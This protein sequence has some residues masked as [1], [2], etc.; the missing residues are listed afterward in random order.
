MKMSLL[1]LFFCFNALSS[2][3]YVSLPSIM[4]QKVLNFKSNSDREVVSIK[5]TEDRILNLSRHVHNTKN[6]CGGFVVT[7]KPLQKIKASLNLNNYTINRPDLVKSYI[8]QVSEPRLRAF[9]EYYSSYKTRYYKAKIGI[10]AMYDLANKWR[11]ITKNRSDITVTTIKHRGWKQPSVVVKV[12]G[13]TS[14]KIIIGGHGDSINTDDEGVHSHAPGADD[15]ASGISV[16]T[17]VLKILVDN[18]YKSTNE[19]QFIAYSAEE[20][21]LRGSM[22]IAETY[23]NKS[24]EIMGVL[25]FDGTNFNGSRIKF[26]L[27]S[28]NTDQKQNK[29]LGRLI[30]RYLKVPWGYDSCYYA[31]SDHYSWNYNGFVASFPAESKIKEENSHIHTVQDTI[32]VSGNN[33]NHAVHFARLGLAYIVELDK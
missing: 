9:I 25:Q 24:A 7:E 4:A 5:T 30:N 18:N 3:V 29:F 22:A 16:I 10:K 33:A 31:C 8:S 19:L 28:D 15:N 32:E 20:V 23:S 17:E 11:E 12:K 27:V 14:K 26:A 13:S 1:I 2:E 21:G 6:H